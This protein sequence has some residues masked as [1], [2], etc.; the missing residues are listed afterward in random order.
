M[1]HDTVN[2]E[3]C[4]SIFMATPKQDIV[5]E[6]KKPQLVSYPD[7]CF[8]FLRN[9]TGNTFFLVV[10]KIAIIPDSA[11][12]DYGPPPVV[13]WVANGDHP[14]KTNAT[15]ELTGNGDL[16]LNDVDGRC[17]WS[18]RTSYSSVTLLELADGGNL[19]L[20]SAGNVA[21]WQ[22]FDHPKHT[23]VPRQRLRI[24]S[25]LTSC[26]SASNFSTR[27][28]YLRVAR[29]SLHAFINTKPL[30]LYSTMRSSSF[31]IMYFKRSG[32]YVTYE[33]RG[34]YFQYVRLEPDGHLNVYRL[35]DGY[36]KTFQVDLLEDSHYKNCAYPT[37]CGIY[38]VCNNEQ[39]TCRG[40]ISGTSN[41]FRRLDANQP[42]L[43]CAEVTPLS[44]RDTR[45]HTFL[46]LKNVSNFRFKA[47]LFQYRCRELQNGMLENCSCKAAMFRYQGNISM[48]NCSLRQQMFSL[49]AT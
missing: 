22:S 33:D 38:G 1:I 24:N 37:V 36:K 48:G 7:F 49:M 46:E 28:F 10:L 26:N 42:S 6:H 8:G 40:E 2:P 19:R 25:T 23:W 15:L 30:E 39:C 34:G 20:V 29:N 35:D 45:L 3:E 18:T 41:Y 43:G 14:V 11:F 31:S 13:I 27:L 17:V 21:V 9:G 16:V 32:N 47:Q 5:L 44:C 12:K 4:A